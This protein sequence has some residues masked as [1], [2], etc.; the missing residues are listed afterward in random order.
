VIHLFYYED[1][2]IKEIA[3]TLNVS[4]NTVKSQLNR[5]RTLLKAKLKEKWE[6]E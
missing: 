3:E 5:G 4:E 1:Y 6:D 2:K